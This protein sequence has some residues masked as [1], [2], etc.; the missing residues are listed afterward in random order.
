MS[1]GYPFPVPLILK[2]LNYLLKIF[3]I[4]SLIFGAVWREIEAARKQVG[5]THKFPSFLVP[6]KVLTISAAAPECDFP[7]EPNPELSLPV[8]PMVQP[9]QDLQEVDPDLYSFI[10]RKPTILLAL[11][12]HVA[13]TEKM[14]IGL[15]LGFKKVLEKNPDVQILWKVRTSSGS[16]KENGMNFDPLENIRKVLG[17]ELAQDRI[18]IV[19]W[20]KADPVSILATGHIICSINHGGAN[21]YLEAVQ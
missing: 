20:L 2:P 13:T 14:S 5:L 18:R 16:S 10:S 7:F 21:S 15:S 12:S 17:V 11:G 8:G 9:I 3:M 6:K 4:F 1:S 19:D